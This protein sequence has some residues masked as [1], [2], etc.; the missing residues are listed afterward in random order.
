[1]PTRR[2]PSRREFIK[3]ASTSLIAYYASGCCDQTPCLATPVFFGFKEFAP[4][5]GAPATLRVFFPSLDG[6][7]QNASLYSGCGKYPLILLLHGDGATYQTWFD[8][9][10]QLAR[11][12][13]IV[14]VPDVNRGPNSDL[15]V[16][17]AGPTA[18]LRWLKRR[19]GEFHNSIA[20]RLGVCGHSFGAS[21]ALLTAIS[22]NASAFAGLSGE[23]GDIF[24][25]A[26]PWQSLPCPAYLGWGTGDH[27]AGVDSWDLSV[28]DAAIQWN[29]I[30]RPKHVVTM[31][32]AHHYD[33]ITANSIGLDPSYGRGPCSY[34]PEISTDFLTT[35][36]SKY[37]GPDVNVTPNI[38]DTLIPDPFTRTPEQEFFYGGFMLGFARFH[39]NQKTGTCHVSQYWETNNTVTPT[40]TVFLSV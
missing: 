29:K 19:G 20:D 8:L 35:F 18:V 38:S 22:L 17:V 34:M 40:G 36:F 32:D 7:P 31:F 3:L 14:A 25:G 12:G 16:A 1:M 39:V 23:Y 10:A 15:Q 21:Q 6:S 2:V 24:N 13:F 30:N 33:Y 4:N 5:D 27:T 11:V 26:E 28:A 37:M 9:P